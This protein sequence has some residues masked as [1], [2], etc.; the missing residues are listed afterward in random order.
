MRQANPQTL[1]S[2]SLQAKPHGAL[3]KQYNNPSSYES[4]PGRPV[5]AAQQ[6]PFGDMKPKQTRDHLQIGQQ[7][8]TRKSI[9]SG[10]RTGIQYMTTCL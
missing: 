1:Q 6:R 2:S 9:I 4:G 8:N 10:C 3:N 7:A 5:K